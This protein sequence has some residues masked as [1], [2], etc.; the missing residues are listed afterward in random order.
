MPRLAHLYFKTAICFLIL[1][2]AMGL[3]MSITHQHQVAGAHAHN[4]LLGWVTMAIFGGYYALN[5]AKAETRLAIVQYWVYTA[6]V[7]VMISSLYLLLSGN[8]GMEPLVA[9]SSLVTFAGVLLF[10]YIIFMRP[11]AL[12]RP[13]TAVSSA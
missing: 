4:N 9:V 1:G 3:Q 5:P 10:A 7:T 11:K 6:G 12:S 13:T 2:I 8:P